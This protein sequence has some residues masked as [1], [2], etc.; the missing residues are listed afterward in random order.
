MGRGLWVD[1]AKCG[2]QIVLVKDI[3]R[4]FSSDNFAEDGFFWHGKPFVYFK[5]L[6]YNILC[7]F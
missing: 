5:I 3:G 4:N 6:F 1:V 7:V 2:D